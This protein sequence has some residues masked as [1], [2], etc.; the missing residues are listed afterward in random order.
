MSRAHLI[1]FFIV[2]LLTVT[3]LAAMAPPPPGVVEDRAELIVVAEVVSVT[4]LGEE[5]GREHYLAVLQVDDVEKGD[6]QGTVQVRF[7]M[8]I[9]DILPPG[10]EYDA[11]YREGD[12]V[13]AYLQPDKWADSF[14]DPTTYTT[15]ERYHGLEVITPGKNT[16][17]PSPSEVAASESGPPVGMLIGVLL[18]GVV[19]GVLKARMR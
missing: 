4:K 7:F 6:A 2:I 14:H 11:T 12:V 18:V 8:P 3:A 13:R 10:T 17:V 9:G 5:R 1:A 19:L 16:R 15:V